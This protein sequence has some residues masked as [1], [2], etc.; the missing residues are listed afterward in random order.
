KR[1]RSRCE[2]VVSW[3]RGFSASHRSREYWFHPID[4]NPILAILLDPI[5]ID[6]LDSKTVNHEWF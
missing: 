2:L 4:S 6:F 3:E 5:S 1:N